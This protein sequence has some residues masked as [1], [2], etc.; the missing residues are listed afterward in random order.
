MPK[1]FFHTILQKTI[2]LY[3]LSMANIGFI[4]LG[5]MGEPMCSHL[6]DKGDKL[7]VYTRPKAKASKLIEKGATYLD[8][9]KEVAKNSDI[10]FTIVGYPK[11]VYEVYLG[12]DGLADGAKNGQLFCDMT[13]TKPTLEIEIS[14]E[15]SL[16][17]AR[18]VD[19]PVSGG[20]VGARN[21]TLSIMCGGEKEDID[22]LMPFFSALGKNVCHMGPVGS[23]QHTKMS[24]QIVI[25]GTMAGVS[26]ALVYGASAGLDLNK[27]VACISKGAAGC[28]TLDN[29]APRVISGNYNPGFMV[30][31]FI[32]DMSIALEESEKMGLSLPSLA[33]TK[34]L[35]V[36][37]QAQ[38]MGK[39]GTQALVKAL[40][41][42]SGKEV[43]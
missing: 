18:L 19:A 13:T 41:S 12:K 27:M 16:K 26:E 31:H 10:V 5:V 38:G 2:L 9:P 4:G 15:L 22:K 32:K 14:H 35:Y 17:G 43:L 28:W 3:A 33:L 34:Q 40:E 37:I 29:L 23:G 6:I 7:F 8:N 20:D 25:A 30:D 11:D 24:N 42:L 1:Y 21:G 36:A 39:N